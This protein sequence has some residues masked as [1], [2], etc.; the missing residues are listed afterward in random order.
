MPVAM[1]FVDGAA[2]YLPPQ[3]FILAAIN[4]PSTGVV[5]Y[6]A[7]RW[8]TDA[9]PLGRAPRATVRR[10]IEGADMLAWLLWRLE[11]MERIRVVAGEL[12]REFGDEAYTEARR[13]EREAMGTKRR[14]TGVGSRWSSPAGRA[15]T[16]QSANRPRSSRKSRGR[17]GSSLFAERSIRGR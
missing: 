7:I 16:V 2:D 5:E 15:C 4:Y 1:G 6:C 11:R 10:R 13:R 17:S 8:V 12:M 14:E 9:L 3:T